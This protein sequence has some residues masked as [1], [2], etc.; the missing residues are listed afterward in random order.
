MFL[1]ENRNGE[2]EPSREETEELERA[3]E[4]VEKDVQ[5]L[6]RIGQTHGLIEPALLA[7]IMSDIAS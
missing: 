6:Q 7:Q 1:V 4:D 5:N 3:L 2:Y